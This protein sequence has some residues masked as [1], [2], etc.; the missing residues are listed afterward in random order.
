M[1]SN[2]I[3]TCPCGSR[4]EL[5]MNGW[6]I[7]EFDF[8]EPLGEWRTLHRRHIEAAAQFRDAT[9]PTKGHLDRLIER[10]TAAGY[11]PPEATS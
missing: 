4:L 6:L 11:P 2:Y 5:A 10:R 8:S 9:D 3:E 7:R 1:R